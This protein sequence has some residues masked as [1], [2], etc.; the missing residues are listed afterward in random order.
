[1][2]CEH[3]M[4][5]MELDCFKKSFDKMPQNFPILLLANIY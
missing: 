4:N 1:M 5:E 2:K 3:F